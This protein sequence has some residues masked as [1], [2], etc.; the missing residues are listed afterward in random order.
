MLDGL[1]GDLL[2][3]LLLGEVLLQKVGQLELVLALALIC[4]GVGGFNEGPLARRRY[5]RLRRT[6]PSPSAPA[7]AAAL[8]RSGTCLLSLSRLRLRL[9]LWLRRLRLRRRSGRR[10]QLLPLL[11]PAD[12]HYMLRIKVDEVLEVLRQGD[13]KLVSRRGGASNLFAAW[14][15]VFVT[16]DEGAGLELVHI[17]AE[18]PSVHLCP[19][20]RA[21]ETLLQ[22]A[23]RLAGVRRLQRPLALPLDRSGPVLCRCSR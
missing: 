22:V 12:A 11:P 16:C 1:E 15:L 10:G 9:P 17:A 21:R 18:L 3:C 19:G 20:A 4:G 23:Q 14:R 2:D 7:T 6:T 5:R 13:E 8:G